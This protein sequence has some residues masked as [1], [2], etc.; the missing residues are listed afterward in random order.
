MLSA[1]FFV[2]GVIVG[3]VI[4]APA[5]E[6]AAPQVGTLFSAFAS[7]LLLTLTN[8][9]TIIS[10]AAIFAGLGLIG[11]GASCPPRGCWCWASSW[12]RRSGGSG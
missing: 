2:K 11:A 4:A 1:G 6:A 9:A 10:F 3:F 5:R 8:P 12:A 7:T